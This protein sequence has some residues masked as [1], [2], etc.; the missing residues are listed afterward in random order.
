MKGTCEIILK[1]VSTGEVK[2]VKHSNMLT[3]ALTNILQPPATFFS[4]TS[5]ISDWYRKVLP[6]FQGALG[7]VLLFSSALTENATNIMPDLTKGCVGHAGG[8]YTGDNS[9]CGTLN[10]TESGPVTNGY[11]NVWDFATNQANGTIAAVAL[12]SRFGGECGLKNSLY[13]MASALYSSSAANT[14]LFD[15]IKNYYTD[16][17]DNSRLKPH[18]NIQS[19]Q[20]ENLS[21]KEVVSG[22]GYTDWTFAGEFADGVLTYFKV[23]SSTEIDIANVPLTKNLSVVDY[24][25]HENFAI[26]DSMIT[27]CTTTHDFTKFTCNKD[28]YGQQYGNVF[29]TQDAAILIVPSTTS[30]GAPLNYVKIMNTGLSEEAQYAVPS[31]AG[32]LYTDNAHYFE[33]NG[34]IFA[35]KYSNPYT[36]IYRIKKSDSSVETINLP[37]SLTTF[38]LPNLQYGSNLLIQCNLKTYLFDGTNFTEAFL[39]VSNVSL[40]DI[41]P[42][43]FLPNPYYYAV[44]TQVGN[45]C[46]AIELNKY[47]IPIVFTPYLGTINNLATAVTKT[48][49]QTMKVIYTLTNS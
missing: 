16:S 34:Y 20:M 23:I 41:I 25:Y 15:A 7:G 21:L 14:N 42:D 28:M 44:T 6:I 11:K 35:P 40:S 8:A 26:D 17:S 9:Y 1:D 24:L 19:S 3:N 5:N 18:Y 37:S 22:Q 49:T 32:I 45:Y 13:D 46:K 36:Q 10:T 47:L 48:A 12:T 27:K 31:D 43:K 29:R 2:S 39:P 4:G 33:L 30:N 38:S